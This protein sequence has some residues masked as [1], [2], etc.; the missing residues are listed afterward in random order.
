MQT[1]SKKPES[2]KGRRSSSQKNKN[3]SMSTNPN[4]SLHAN[5]QIQSS[6]AS[7]KT[8]GRGSSHPIS[9]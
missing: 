2:Q 9:A 7:H 4:A 5:S 6:Q 8:S 1:A 3:N